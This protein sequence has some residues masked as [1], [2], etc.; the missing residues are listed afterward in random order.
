ML[1]CPEK[2]RTEARL[3]SHGK[4]IVRR[5]SRASARDASEADEIIQRAGFAE[6]LEIEREDGGVCRLPKNRAGTIAQDRA[7]SPSAQR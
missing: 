1:V 7:N 6:S 5:G 4:S 2:A 3:E